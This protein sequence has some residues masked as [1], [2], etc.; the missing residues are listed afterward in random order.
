MLAYTINCRYRLTSSSNCGSVQELSNSRIVVSSP[1]GGSCSEGA[2]GKSSV[3]PVLADGEVDTWSNPVD[4]HCDNKKCG[5]VFKGVTRYLP[6]RCPKCYS[7][8]RPP[9][10]RSEW[11]LRERFST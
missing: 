5:N 1:T 4:F 8:A 7:L 3:A 11:Y 6:L 10:T 9:G 2:T